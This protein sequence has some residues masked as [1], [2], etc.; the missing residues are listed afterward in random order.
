MYFLAF[1]DKLKLTSDVFDYEEQSNFVLE[2]TV[3]DDTSEMTS[4]YLT[5]AVND[6]NEPCVFSPEYY[7]ITMYEGNVCFTT[8][9]G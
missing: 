5:I 1:L 8:Y 9:W 6:V 4:Y 2:F 3:S 7:Y